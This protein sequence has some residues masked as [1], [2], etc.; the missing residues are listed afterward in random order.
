MDSRRRYKLS[1]PPGWLASL[2]QVRARFIGHS[3]VVGVGFGLATTKDKLVWRIYLKDRSSGAA[4]EIP[5]RLFHFPTELCVAQVGGPTAPAQYIAAM[6]ISNETKEPGS[7]GCFAKTSGGVPVLLSCAHVLFAN[8]TATA[9]PSLGIYQPDYSTCCGGTRI[10]TTD[11]TLDGGFRAAT[12]GSFDTDCASATLDIGIHYDNS[13]PSI[14]IIDGAHDPVASMLPASLDNLPTDA[15]LLRTYSALN[16]GLRWGTIFRITTGTNDPPSPFSKGPFKDESD[17]A[18]QTRPNVNQFI[19]I[20]RLPPV[21]NETQ[22]AYNARHSKALKDG[23]KLSFAEPGDSGSVVVD[24]DRKVVGLIIRHYSPSDFINHYKSNNLP[25]PIALQITAHVAI[26]TPIT[27]VLA[28]LNVTIPAGYKGV[29]PAR[30]E[31]LQLVMP[32]SSRPDSLNVEPALERLRRQLIASRHGKIIVAKIGKHRSESSRLVSTVRRAT[33][34][35]HRNQGPAFIQHCIRNLRDPSHVI[36]TT[37]NGANRATLLNAMADV[38]LQFGSEALRRDVRRYRAFAT[39]ALEGLTSLHDVPLLL[40]TS[41]LQSVR[42]TE[43]R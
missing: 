19:V 6:A 5:E 40:H 30:G 16:G 2:Q 23:T 8:N 28:H 7:L 41:R 12:P 26:V 43:I 34:A 14:G 10:A 13:L 29:A 15:Q 35:W 11:G 9:A 18:M 27:N 17:A 20:P 1:L 36:P 22:S 42:A 31:N 21:Q 38:F 25:V 32:D 33:V 24:K 37:I 3:G 4:A 39:V